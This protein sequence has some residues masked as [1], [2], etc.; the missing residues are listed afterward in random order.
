MT[1]ELLDFYK[2]RNVRVVILSEYGLTPARRVIYPNRAL[3]LKGWLNIKKELGLEYLDCGGSD[4]FA[5]TDHQIAHIYLNRKD[6]NLRKQVQRELENLDGVAHVLYGKDRAIHGLDHQ[7]AGDLW[8]CWLR[9]M[10][11]LR[12]ITGWMIH[13]PLTS[14]DVWTSTENT[15]TTRRNCL[16]IRPLLCLASKQQVNYWPK[17]WAS[18]FLWI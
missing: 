16:S 10:P 14:P 7:R 5:L 8:F 2:A 9:R 18:A 1:G 12:I 15:V 13:W 17:N 4:A 11:G 6:D 3:R